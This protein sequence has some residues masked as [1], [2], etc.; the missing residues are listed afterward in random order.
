MRG[1]DADEVYAFLATVAD[2]YEAVLNDNKALRERLLE[3]DDKVQEYRNMEK[4]LRDTL[5]TAERVT[6]ESKDSARREA[7]LIIKEAQLEAEKG[8]RNIKESAMRLRQEIQNLKQ[9]RD[10]YLARMKAVVESHMKYL[11]AAEND[12]AEEETRIDDEIKTW[13]NEEEVKREPTI[14]ERPTPAT[15]PP[16]SAASVDSKTTDTFTPPVNPSEPKTSAAPATPEPPSTVYREALESDRPSSVGDVEKPQSKYTLDESDST[17]SAPAAA[18]E[19]LPSAPTAVATEEPEADDKP[20]LKELLDRVIDDHNL[21]APGAEGDDTPSTNG[22]QPAE[23]ASDDKDSKWSLKRLKN[24]ILSR[25]RSDEED[26]SN[27]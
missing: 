16:K 12:F 24:D 1:L 21:D 27:D 9:Q 3:L 22:G 6:V 18:T 26:P 25:S 17:D 23:A 5:L 14:T 11:D 8:V 19:T 10:S 4:T 2:E 20:S 15:K 13:T 7:D